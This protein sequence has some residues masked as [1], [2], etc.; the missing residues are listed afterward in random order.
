MNI[1]ADK[2]IARAKNPDKVTARAKAQPKT[3]VASKRAGDMAERLANWLFVV[4]DHLR[5]VA[6]Q[7][8]PTWFANSLREQ[9]AEIGT[10]AWVVMRLF[11]VGPC[12]APLLLTLAR[13]ANTRL[14]WAVDEL[15][16][17]EEHI[18]MD[19][20]RS[21][22][23]GCAAAARVRSSQPRRNQVEQILE[24]LTRDE[25]SRVWAAVSQLSPPNERARFVRRPGVDHH[26]WQCSGCRRV[27][28]TA[29]TAVCPTC[30]RIDHWSGSVDPDALAKAKAREADPDDVTGPDTPRRAFNLLEALVEA[31]EA[32]PEELVHYEAQSNRFTPTGAGSRPC[33]HL[34]GAMLALLSKKG[35]AP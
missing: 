35:G 10:I 1:A 20:V 7:N 8:V 22:F 9:A 31:G 5:A 21:H 34:Q 26:A 24:G 29:W 3:Y 15:Q 16:R 6:N 12:T 28:L 4:R 19:L 2:I 17:A 11:N 32:T 27:F 30:G 18:R 23:K 25:R 33:T 13:F 14:D